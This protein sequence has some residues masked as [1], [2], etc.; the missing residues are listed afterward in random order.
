MTE[1]ACLAEDDGR[2]HIVEIR[3]E[4]CK[5]KGLGVFNI[6]QLLADIEFGKQIQIGNKTESKKCVW[7]N[8]L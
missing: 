5:H 2:I 6:A 1:F 4:V 3:D 7:E 8:W